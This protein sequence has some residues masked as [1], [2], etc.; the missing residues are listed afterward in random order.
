M[1]IRTSEK[2]NEQSLHDLGHFSRRE[3]LN[4]GRGPQQS[5]LEGK[6]APKKRIS[7]IVSY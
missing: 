7:M 4:F 6:K 1:P 3:C 2:D 5:N